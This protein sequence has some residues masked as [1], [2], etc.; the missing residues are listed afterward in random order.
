[1][2]EQEEATV[3][4]ETLDK[5]E[6]LLKKTAKPNPWPYE[7]KTC[8]TYALIKGLRELREQYG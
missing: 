3:V 1:M 5:V 4:R 8:G 7:R 2:T 6:A